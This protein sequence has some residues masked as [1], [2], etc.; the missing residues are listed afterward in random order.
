MGSRRCLG[1][2]LGG[3]GMRLLRISEKMV[4]VKR[5]FNVKTDRMD[6]PKLHDP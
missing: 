6:G 5:G 4:M 2:C 3:R 1:D